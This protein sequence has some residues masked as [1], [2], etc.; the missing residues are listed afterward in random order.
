MREMFGG[1]RLW[2]K[3][4]K[5][6]DDQ[7][8]SIKVQQLREMFMRRKIEKQNEEYKLMMAAFEKY[9]KA[10]N[11]Q[12]YEKENL[13]RQAQR[14]VRIKNRRASDSALGFKFYFHEE[15]EKYEDCKVRKKFFQDRNFGLD[16]MPAFERKFHH[17]NP[18]HCEKFELKAEDEINYH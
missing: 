5:K 7:E 9:C 1:L 17:S 2:K 12:Y 11:E 15:Y 8:S 18:L 10:Y 13:K 4:K 3:A 6:L 14:Y 16:H